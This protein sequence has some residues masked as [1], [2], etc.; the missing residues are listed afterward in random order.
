[1]LR[2]LRARFGASPAHFRAALHHG[3]DR[4]HSITIVGA[5]AADLGA[6]TARLVVHL[7]SPEH[8]I[9]AGL[10][11][12]DAISHQADVI[13]LG[14]P[15]S[16]LQTVRHRFQAN[17]VAILTILDALPHFLGDLAL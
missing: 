11:N 7:G 16:H 6:Y 4:I 9:G 10:A 17:G 13:R 2:H 15:A 3:V 1:M 8:E 5:T 12:L 14:V